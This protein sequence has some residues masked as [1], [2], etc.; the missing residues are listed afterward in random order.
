MQKLK[1]K[2]AVIKYNCLQESII[3]FFFISLS[4]TKKLCLWERYSIYRV[5]PSNKNLN[6]NQVDISTL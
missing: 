4:Y 1:A 5:D 2:N 6:E 3:S